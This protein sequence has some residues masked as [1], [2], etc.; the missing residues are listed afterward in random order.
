MGYLAVIDCRSVRHKIHTDPTPHLSCLNN[1]AIVSWKTS[2]T[3]H[4]VRRITMVTRLL[5]IRGY[6]GYVVTMD[7]RLPWISSALSP[8]NVVGCLLEQWGSVLSLQES[9]VARVT[10]DVIVGGVEMTSRLVSSV[11]NHSGGCLYVS[12]ASSR[13]SLSSLLRP[14]SL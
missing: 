8:Y 5:W 14:L 13:L 3:T 6:Y 9:L 1:M 12:R 10:S 2:L 11:A 7:T 4:T